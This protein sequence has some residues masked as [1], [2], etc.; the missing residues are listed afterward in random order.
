MLVNK[1]AKLIVIFLTFAF[2]LYI[3]IKYIFF[4]KNEISTRGT[5]KQLE[6]IELNLQN[7]IN[8]KFQNYTELKIKNSDIFAKNIVN[9]NNL[10]NFKIFNHTNTGIIIGKNKFLFSDVYLIEKFCLND[11]LE[12]E[13]IKEWVEKIEKVQNILKSKNIN[14]VYVLAPNKADFYE[15]YIPYKFKNNCNDNRKYQIFIDE[16]KKTNI[17]FVDAN[18]Y[19]LSLKD[20][21][22][23]AMGAYVFNNN[24]EKL[25]PKYGIHWTSYGFAYFMQN[26]LIPYLEN[27]YNKKFNDIEFSY[28]NSKIPLGSDFD[29][30]YLLGIQNKNLSD[31]ILYPQLK[32]NKNNGYKP[33]LLMIGDSFLDIMS[34]NLN[35]YDYFN[36]DLQNIN[37][38]YYSN[39]YFYDENNVFKIEA[40]EL[41]VKEKMNYIKNKELI[42]FL[43][44][45]PQI[46]NNSMYKFFDDV[47]N[48]F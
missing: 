1:N 37:W 42:I 41:D 47:I 40:L 26:K 39:R 9:L 10:L 17:N 2:L 20:K 44:T 32:E 3:T 30:A 6:K 22:N 25:F 16:I 43:H 14:F 29:L 11:S 7:F 33:K 35:I 13:K 8:N 48:N 34:S 45:T 4:S 19:F 38:S 28:T 12:R 15:E 24:N 46:L 36:V 23:K 27:L 31:E 5:E 18:E 21:M